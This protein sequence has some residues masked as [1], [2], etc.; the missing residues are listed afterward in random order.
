VQVKR[1]FEYIVA[2]FVLLC[3]VSAVLPFWDKYKLRMDLKNIAVY[4]TKNDLRD[5]NQLL[6]KKIRDRG[7]EYEQENLILE[8]DGENTVYVQLTYTD[9]IGMFGITVKELEFTVEATAREITGE[10]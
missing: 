10:Y 7:V 8:K 1:I 9:R 6:K 4:G 2:V 3:I 5:T